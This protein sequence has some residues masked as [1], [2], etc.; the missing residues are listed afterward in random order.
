MRR[1]LLLA[2]LAEDAQAQPAPTLRLELAGPDV[3]A[4]SNAH[5]GFGGRNIPDAPARAIRLRS[6]EVQL[7]AA[8]QDNR[9]NTGPDLLHVRHRCPV[10]L[11]G[12]G[13][14]DP[15]AYDDRAWIAS[16]W[17]PDGDTVFAIVSNEFQGHR[18]PTLCP[19]GRYMDCWFDTLTAAVSE[20]G[21]FRRGAG[22][23]LVA[24]LPY[25]FGELDLVHKGYF[26][27]TNTVSAGRAQCMFAFATRAGAQQPGN[28]LLRTNDIDNPGAWRA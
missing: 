27:P 8:D 7:Y 10:V 2:L 5:P 25:R 23:A 16:P 18:R 24:A 15:A 3:P 20:G 14:D 19:S 28:C 4:I 26:K 1:L 22:D 6:G 12:A 21:P 13:N 11:R 9:L 17:T